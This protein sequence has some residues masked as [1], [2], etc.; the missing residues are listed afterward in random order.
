MCI[1]GVENESGILFKVEFAKFGFFL[2]FEFVSDG[3]W[4]V[5]SEALLDDFV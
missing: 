4:G 2:E 5:D 3:Y 1:I